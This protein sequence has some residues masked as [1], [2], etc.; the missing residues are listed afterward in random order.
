MRRKDFS[1]ENS[2]MVIPSD[3]GKIVDERNTLWQKFDEAQHQFD[4]MNKLAPQIASSVA[5]QIPSELTGHKTP[6]LEVIAAA[7]NFQ[8]ELTRIAKAEETIQAHQTEIKKVESQQL[9]T[10]VVVG[11]LIGAFLCF[12]AFGGIAVIN[13]IFSNR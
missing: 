8:A 9:T 7:Q 4:E 10:V 2:D 6:P 13:S 1:M 5:A 12:L 3:I 11:I